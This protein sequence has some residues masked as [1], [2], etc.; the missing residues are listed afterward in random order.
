VFP[1]NDTPV[2]ARLFHS[3]I[4]RRPVVLQTGSAAKKRKRRK[5][6]EDQAESATRMAGVLHLTQGIFADFKLHGAKVH[7]KAMLNPR[8]P[9]V[10]KQLGN[11]LVRQS[12]GRLQLDDEA[13][14]Q[15][16]IGIVIADFA[17]YGWPLKTSFAC[18]WKPALLL[19]CN[20]LESLPFAKIFYHGLHGLHGWKPEDP[21]SF[22]I[23]VIRGIRGSSRLVVALP[24][25]V[26]CAFL[27]LISL[28]PP[29]TRAGHPRLRGRPPRPGALCPQ[30]PGPK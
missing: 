23:R 2:T 22:H 30:T 20:T 8:R 21:K 1:A 24:R 3:G 13:I 4:R 12:F 27:R 9:Q 25:F 7:Q 10:A 28:P 19:H 11:M 16:K 5:K 26:F 6:G 18:F 29:I 17:F 14:V 15:Q